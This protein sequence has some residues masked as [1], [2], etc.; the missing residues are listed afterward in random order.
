MADSP[1]KCDA[2]KRAKEQGFVSIFDGESFNGWR[3]TFKPKTDAQKKILE[4]T[5]YVKDGAIVLDTFNIKPEDRIRTNEYLAT[6]KKYGDFVLRFG[7]Q[8]ERKW[9][10][11]GNSGIEVRNGLQFD[12]QP[13]KPWLIGW[14]WD[15]GPS[16]Y[17]W[18]SPIKLERRQC[19]ADGPWL[20]GQSAEK[21]T[22]GPW[23]YS[24][25]EY[26]PKGFKFYYADEGSGWNDVEIICKGVH[27]KFVLNG[28]VMSDFDGSGFLDIGKRKNFH[29]TAPIMFQAH[30]DDGVIIRFKDIRVKE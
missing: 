17:G 23:R 19:E 6:E 2:A 22:T 20:H 29:P 9:D 8:V 30:N 28:V 10:K 21:H 11:L 25:D 26:A 24:K 5:F 4:R 27:F 12:M 1:D 14:I 18:L 15:H 7:M 16:S 3:A 13:P